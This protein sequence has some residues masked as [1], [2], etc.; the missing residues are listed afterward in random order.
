M[1][2]NPNNLPILRRG[3]VTLRAPRPSDAD[4]FID[5]ARSSRGLHDEL[6]HPPETRAAFEIYVGRNESALNAC[7]LIIENES[8][9]IAGTINLS[10]I[11]RGAFLNAYL[12]YYL[13]EGFTGRGLMTEAMKAV[14][15]FA[16][17]EFGLHRLEAN[18]QP[19][20]TASRKLVET[21][22]FKKE[23]F[24][25]K[26]LWIAGDWR[27]HERWAIINENLHS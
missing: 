5:A 8:G 9:R 14:I 1:S 24:S 21:C 13:F 20:N 15:E 17:E 10:Q 22:G 4:E 25:E 26:Y 27:D 6:V 7:F 11:F 18:I 23:G 12:G 3:P 2:S 16:F 19:R